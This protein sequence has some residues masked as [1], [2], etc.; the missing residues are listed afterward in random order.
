MEPKFENLPR[1][2]SSSEGAFEGN[3]RVPQT[4]VGIALLGLYALLNSGDL[5][6]E[7]NSL[8]APVPIDDEIRQRV[9]RSNAQHKLHD[10]PV[11]LTEE[12]VRL[13]RI[14][15]KQ[16]VLFL[17]HRTLFGSKE[18]NKFV[19]DRYAP[20]EW[21]TAK[22]HQSAAEIKATLDKETW[23]TLRQLVAIGKEAMINDT[24]HVL[25]IKRKKLYEGWA[26]MTE[27]QQTE[28]TQ[29]SRDMLAAHFEALIKSILSESATQRIDEVLTRQFCEA[30]Q[31]IYDETTA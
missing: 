14:G 30:L 6:I 19:F 8:T 12:R 27:Q 26:Q 11:T 20:D 2:K 13:M 28:A 1:K 7:I 16:N 5:D 9:I 18:N 10:I 17:L 23:Q 31:I 4:F 21:A 22:E 24:Q 15:E 29:Q 25:L 3:V